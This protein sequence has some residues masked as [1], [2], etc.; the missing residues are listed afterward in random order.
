VPD[1]DAD[2]S[3][4]EP[5]GVLWIAEKPNWWLRSPAYDSA[6]GGVSLMAGAA[7]GSAVRLGGA[8]A[9]LTPRSPRP[10]AADPR[11]HVST[12]VTRRKGGR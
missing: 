6:G 11:L 4:H 5:V 2:A 12:V 8:G 7:A 1:R 10:D 9:L 3:F